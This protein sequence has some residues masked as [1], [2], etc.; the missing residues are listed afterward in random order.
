MGAVEDLL[1]YRG[2]WELTEVRRYY[3][4][5][6]VPL[7]VSLLADRADGDLRWREVSFAAGAGVEGIA[8]VVSPVSETVTRGVVLAHGGSDDGRR[9]FLSEAASLAAQGAAVILPVTRIRQNAGVDAFAADVR[10][11]VLNER[12]ALDVLVEAGAPPDALSFLGHSGGGALGAIL[13]AVEPRLAQIVIFANGAGAVIRSALACG[14]SRGG[15]V[16]EGLAAV[17]DWFDLA[18]FVGVERRAQLLVQ[19]GRADQ[20]VPIQAGRALFDAA[21]SPKLWAEYDW[22]HGLD[23]D[24]QA[25]KDRAEFVMAGA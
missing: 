8:T 12:A 22:D 11:A 9:F 25:R 16:T 5:P 13:C 18:H 19:H 4:R 10:N 21:A 20:T 7:L 6:R 1:P 15:E 23:A 14:L 24:P 2:R 17:A 3:A